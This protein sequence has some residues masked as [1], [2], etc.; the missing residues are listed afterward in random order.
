[1]RYWRYFGDISF[2]SSKQGRRCRIAPNFLD[3][4]KAI[5]V[6]VISL[7]ASLFCAKANAQSSYM[8]NWHPQPRCVTTGAISDGQRRPPTPALVERLEACLSQ[9]GPTR[10]ARAA[11]AQRPSDNGLELDR[12]YNELMR[13]RQDNRVSVA[14]GRARENPNGEV[15]ER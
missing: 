10:V 4:T 11:I 5:A 15:Q 7:A 9:Y 1:M 2:A 3:P 14:T 12:I 13:I 8:E 6:G